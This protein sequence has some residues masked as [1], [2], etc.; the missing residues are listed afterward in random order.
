MRFTP[1]SVL[2]VLLCG[3]ISAAAQL[4]YVD[5]NSA[6]PTA[7]FTSWQSAAT[8]IQDAIDVADPGDQILVTNG[9]YRTGA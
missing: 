5:I 2:G 1:G 4:H 8:N 6:N 7:P 3:I 9:I